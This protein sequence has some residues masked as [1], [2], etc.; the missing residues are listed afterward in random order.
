VRLFISFPTY[1][2][3]RAVVAAFSP[4]G[5]EPVCVPFFFSFFSNYISFSVSFSLWKPSRRA[6]MRLSRPSR[7]RLVPLRRARHVDPD[8]SNESFILLFFSPP[9]FFHSLPLSLFIIAIYCQCTYSFIYLHPLF[10]I[11]ASRHFTKILFHCIFIQRDSI[12]RR[13]TSLEL[14]SRYN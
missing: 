10:L 2:I 5:Q 6:Q 11:L 8:A 1:L 12:R 3:P 9:L 13:I 4:L 7:F 14:N